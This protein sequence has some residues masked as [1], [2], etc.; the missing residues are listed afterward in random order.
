MLAI[1][2]RM[3]APPSNGTKAAECELGN[4]KQQHN[5]GTGIVPGGVIS[6]HSCDSDAGHSSAVT[7]LPGWTPHSV[8]H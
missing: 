4:D 5:G 8:T 2:Q 7:G 1:T 3:A 6:G